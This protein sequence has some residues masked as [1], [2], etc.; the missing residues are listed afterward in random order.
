MSLQ[1][2]FRRQQIVEVLTHGF[3]LFITQYFP[4][5]RIPERDCPAGIYHNYGILS[6][7][8]N[9]SQTAFALFQRFLYLFAFGNVYIKFSYQPMSPGILE[10]DCMHFNC[11]VVLLWKKFFC[12]DCLPAF[13]SFRNSASA[14]WFLQSHEILVAFPPC[15]ITVDFLPCRINIS[16]IE[17]WIDN[18]N[19]CLC[20]TQYIFDSPSFLCKFFTPSVFFGYIPEDQNSSYDCAFLVPYGSTVMGNLVFRTIPGNK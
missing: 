12:N 20:N 8:C 16:K 9:A 5:C 4:G 10:G 13:Q 1:I 17:F 19:T 3:L 14:T 6:R 7:I 15:G 2:S 11:A 18:I